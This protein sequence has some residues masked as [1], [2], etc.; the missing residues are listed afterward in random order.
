MLTG[1]KVVI[2]GGSSG[3][4]LE[5]A[6]RAAAEGAEIVI[7]SRSRHKLEQAK[8]AIGTGVKVTSHILDV[9]DE[10]QVRLFFEQTGTF[11][12]LVVSAAETSGGPFLQ[13]R[14]ALPAR[15]SRTNSGANIMPPNM[16]LRC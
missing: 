14:Q 1:Q 5:T 7:A 10:E 12:H 16:R 8:A 13:R 4:G 6:R 11:D 3:I 9:T 15:C 2:V